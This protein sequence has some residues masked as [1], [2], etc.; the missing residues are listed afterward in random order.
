MPHVQKF[1]AK[2]WEASYEF[3]I[4]G[5]SNHVGGNGLALWFTDEPVC[6]HPQLSVA[7]LTTDRARAA[8]RRSCDVQ[9]ADGRRDSLSAYCK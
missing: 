5:L 1:R 6:A 9:R 3:R 4:F 2:S 8:L 7:H